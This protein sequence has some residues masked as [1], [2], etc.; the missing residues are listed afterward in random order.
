MTSMGMRCALVL[1]RSTAFG[2]VS[3]S[4]GFECA[5]FDRFAI[6]YVR[7]QTWQV[8]KGVK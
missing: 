8:L 1:L 7:Q 3:G 5:G 6:S 4:T 2:G